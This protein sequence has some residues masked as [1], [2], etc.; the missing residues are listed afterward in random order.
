MK[1]LT[2]YSVLFVLLNICFLFVYG[3][4]GKGSHSKSKTMFTHGDAGA[5]EAGGSE[6]GEKSGKA[7]FSSRGGHLK[8]YQVSPEDFERLPSVL[9]LIRKFNQ[10]DVVEQFY[11][12]TTQFCHD[13]PLIY[14]EIQSDL[15]LAESIL[16]TMKTL[17][18]SLSRKPLTLANI[19]FAV[20]K[21][22]YPLLK[23]Q[24]VPLKKLSDLIK[25]LEANDEKNDQD[26]AKDQ[27]NDK[28]KE[29]TMARIMGNFF[30]YFSLREID[31]IERF[32]ELFC[33][34]TIN[35]AGPQYIDISETSLAP[36]EVRIHSVLVNTFSKMILLLDLFMKDP[37][38]ADHS[39]K[40]V[41]H[42]RLVHLLRV[43]ESKNDIPIKEL[44]LS[45]SNPL[46]YRK[47]NINFPFD[48][49]TSES[50]AKQKMELFRLASA[51]RKEKERQ[52]SA[53]GGSE[54]KAFKIY[55]SRGYQYV[56]A[57]SIIIPVLL[58][59]IGVFLYFK[60]RRSRESETLSL[61]LIEDLKYYGDK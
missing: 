46:N 48:D 11:T 53:A 17:S 43:S 56:I 14:A 9:Y 54:A 42:L 45:Y 19:I 21:H 13:I 38:I 27:D 35:P 44:P 37:L 31:E 5:G 26:S 12:M 29:R 4:K 52:S 39:D 32:I 47:L 28:V 2:T 57:A 6:N 40:I 60:H 61:D 34:A 33:R 20:G 25:L 30:R 18:E 23:Y 55:E 16:S 50:D 1:R 41:N 10:I 3:G 49:W 8:Q 36:Y 22:I 24:S 58:L 7:S 59:L 15:V 51:A